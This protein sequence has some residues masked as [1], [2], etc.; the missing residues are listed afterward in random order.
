MN[1]D[2]MSAL[3]TALGLDGHRLAADVLINHGWCN[4]TGQRLV[5]LLGRLPTHMS[6]FLRRSADNASGARVWFRDGASHTGVVVINN[7][8]VVAAFTV[9]TD[10]PPS[11]GAGTPPGPAGPA[12]FRP[13]PGASTGMGLPLVERPEFTWPTQGEMAGYGLDDEDLIPPWARR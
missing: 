8:E 1:T 11:S 2:L 7:G 9:R 4:A 6:E 13:S 5:D 12:G 10:P 3:A